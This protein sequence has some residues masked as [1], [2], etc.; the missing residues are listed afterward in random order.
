M[1]LTMKNLKLE[2]NHN[3]LEKILKKLLK[4]LIINI[5]QVNQTR[6]IYMMMNLLIFFIFM[7]YL[8]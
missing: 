7:N 3:Y 4:E 1:K 5:E 2:Y 8:K 6:H